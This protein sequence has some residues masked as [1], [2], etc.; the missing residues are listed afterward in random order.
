[1]PSICLPAD[2]HACSETHLGSSE[3]CRNYF[4]AILRALL[5]RVHGQTDGMM[6]IQDSHFQFLFILRCESRSRSQRCV[7]CT[8]C[9]ASQAWAGGG[10]RGCVVFCGWEAEKLG[11]APVNWGSGNKFVQQQ[12]ASVTTTVK[13]GRDFKWT[14]GKLYSF[15][16]S[17]A[18]I[19]M[20]I[21]NLLHSI[22]LAVNM[23]KP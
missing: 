8:E 3:C 12:Q 16:L 17:S 4:R 23:D 20:H 5:H 15:V 11:L 1:M 2:M 19:V 22:I 7:R 10:S 14:R 18:F 9:D 13:S 21:T 6:E